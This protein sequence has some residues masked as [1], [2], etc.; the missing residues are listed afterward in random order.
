MNLHWS[1]LHWPGL[2]W[3]GLHWPGLR[4]PACKFKFPA[5][6]WVFGHLGHFPQ[7]DP[8]QSKKG[9]LW[10]SFCWYYPCVSCANFFFG[11]RHLQDRNWRKGRNVTQN[12]SSQR[13]RRVLT[14]GGAARNG[15]PEDS[16]LSGEVHLD[17]GIAP[18]VVD[19]PRVNLADRHVGGGSLL[20]AQE[21]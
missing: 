20:E 12:G 16:F 1:S 14:C 10:P 4:W 13:G 8:W 6:T 18:R 3:P 15:R 17:R 11:R 9:R 5:L 21:V 2:H 19:H 7:R